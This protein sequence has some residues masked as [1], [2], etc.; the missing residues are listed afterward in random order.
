MNDFGRVLTVMQEMSREIKNHKKEGAG[1]V[2]AAAGGL[3]LKGS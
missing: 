2:A 1:A 3:I